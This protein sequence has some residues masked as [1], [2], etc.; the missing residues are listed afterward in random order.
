MDTSVLDAVVAGYEPLI[1]ALTL[2]DP[3][4]RH[5]LAAAITCRASCIVTFNLA[6]FPL[7]A[8]E[9]FGLHAVHPDEFLLDVESLSPSEFAAAVKE[10]LEHYTTPPISASGFADRLRRA[11]VPQTADHIERLSVMLDV[12]RG[13]NDCHQ[14]TTQGRAKARAARDDRAD[15]QGRPGEASP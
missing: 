6:D 11:G 9:P 10:D 4:D 13:E 5:V 15:R 14:Q 2:P 3:D 1:P 12:P 7:S 8:L